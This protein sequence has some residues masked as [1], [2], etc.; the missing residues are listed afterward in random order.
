MAKYPE[1]ARDAT[2]I[3]DYPPILREG[4]NV[5]APVSSGFLCSTCH[6]P[7]TFDRYV[8][9]SVRFPNGAPLSTGNADSNL[10]LNCHQGRESKLSVDSA[11]ADLDPDTISEKLRFINIHYFAAGATLF[12]NA[13]QGAYQYDGNEYAG[14]LAHVPGF[15]T[16]VDC[17]DGHALTVQTEKCAQCHGTEDLDAIRISDV[18][19]DGDGDVTEGLVE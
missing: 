11:V 4:V 16:C 3:V 14:Q 19:Y 10:C 17:H 1:V 9:E 8:V 13:S 6:D 7:A 15:T 2:A 5:S 18:D 12:G